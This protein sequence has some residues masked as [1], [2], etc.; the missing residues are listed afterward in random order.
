MFEA[1]HEQVVAL[2]LIRRDV[3]TTTTTTTTT[4]SSGTR[5]LN[6]L[7]S[8]APLSCNSADCGLNRAPG[9]KA[10]LASPV[11]H[12]S[13]TSLLPISARLHG[14]SFNQPRHATPHAQY[15]SQL[16]RVCT[17]SC[18]PLGKVLPSAEDHNRAT[19]KRAHQPPEVS[20]SH[21]MCGCW[22]TTRTILHEYEV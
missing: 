18:G 6:S 21:G 13:D 9:R 15:E 12:R 10:L 1:S 20:H 22:C 14:G 11:E 16:Y 3:L 4:P 2:C 7:Q 19:C 5:H 17:I 8:S